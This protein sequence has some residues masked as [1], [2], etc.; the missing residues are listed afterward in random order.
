MGEDK[1]EPK[2]LFIGEGHEQYEL[3]E[4]LGPF[5]SDLIERDPQYNCLAFEIPSDYQRERKNFDLSY[6]EF[7][8]VSGRTLEEVHQH[9]F[10]YWFELRAIFLENEG[11]V[12][13][14]DLPVEPNKHPEY[15]GHLN[16]MKARNKW[17][18]K[19]LK[20]L[21]ADGTCQKIISINGRAHLEKKTEWYQA[22]PI[23]KFLRGIKTATIDINEFEELL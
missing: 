3:K 8:N 7:A 21:L 2:I 22:P 6:E 18:A 1:N 11:R 9:G 14:I 20:R 13:A 17:M 5:I 12:F 15:R 16:G 23:K 4:L 19:N 10:P